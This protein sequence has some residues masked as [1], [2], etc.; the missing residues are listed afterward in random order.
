M[1]NG[2]GEGMMLQGKKVI[3]KKLGEGIIK[4]TDETSIHIQ[5][6]TS[7]KKF[8][9]PECFGTFLQL[10][11]KQDE[12]Y[13]TK[14]EK[15]KP[16]IPLSDDI[17]IRIVQL[18]LQ[19]PKLLLEQQEDL[20]EALFYD[21]NVIEKEYADAK[22]SLCIMA[23]T[24][25]KDFPIIPA[26]LI[27]T[28]S[29]DTKRQYLETVVLQ[30][31]WSLWLIA[32]SESMSQCIL[33]INTLS[34]IQQKHGPSELF[35]KNVQTKYMN[36]KIEFSPTLRKKAIGYVYPFAEKYNISDRL[37]R[38]SDLDVSLRP[39]SR[40]APF[41]YLENW[42]F[43]IIYQDIYFYKEYST[44]YSSGSKMCAVIVVPLCENICRLTRHCA[45]KSRFQRKLLK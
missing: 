28:K 44:Y 3:H 2:Y 15:T 9:Y 30:E 38:P 37:Y 43:Y 34:C 40:P 29:K 17:F 16:D 25:L 27:E 13:I 21:G 5:F 39:D 22:N 35:H 8:K 18:Y 12:K 45:K 24:E 7:V 20:L 11:D 19:D 14:P 10:A 32:K 6:E 26:I 31:E 4:K 41:M 42:D 23:N 33:A 36:H 1:G